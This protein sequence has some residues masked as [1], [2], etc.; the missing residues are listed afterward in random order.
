[1][2]IAEDSGTTGG[3]KRE[4]TR[5]ALIAAALDVVEAKGFAG[6]SLDA[7]AAKAGMTKGAIYSNFTGKAELLLAAMGSRGFVMSPSQ[8]WGTVLRDGLKAL[9]SEL[10]AMIRRAQGEAK[11]AVEFELY[12]M[13]DAELRAGM[14]V[15]YASL[16]TESAAFFARFRDLRPGL[17]PR[18]V[19]VML[20]ATAL[21]LLV[22]SFL[23][24]DEITEEVVLAALTALADGVTAPPSEPTPP[25]SRS[26]RSRGRGRAAP[27]RS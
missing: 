26:P 16:F 2:S 10:T 3:G 13:T 12:A 22:Q 6:A 24:P 15:T 18:H 23:T 20:Q 14:A 8:A 17:A 27:P 1:M 25:S 21:G 4:R 5:A 11:F 19:A 9:A 7:I